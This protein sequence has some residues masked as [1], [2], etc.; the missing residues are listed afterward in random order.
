MVYVTI[1]NLCH[2][3]IQINYYVSV[4]FYRYL[5]YQNLNCS[6][7]LLVETLNTKTKFVVSMKVKMKTMV[8]WGVRPDRSNFHTEHGDRRF[9]RIVSD[10]RRNYSVVI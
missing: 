2:L 6:D 10:H 9:F 4:P 3:E 5:G 7:N 1:R 8:F